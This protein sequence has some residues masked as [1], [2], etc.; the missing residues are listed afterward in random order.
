MK[1][2]ERYGLTFIQAQIEPN[3]KQ[4]AIAQYLAV[5]VRDDTHPR[6]VCQVPP[7]QGKSRVAATAALINSLN[8]SECTDKVHMVYPTE[9]LLQRDQSIFEKYWTFNKLHERVQYHVGLEFE[10]HADDLIIIDESD[11]LLFE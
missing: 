1:K 11:A 5:A 4:F 6:L 3:N 9:Y 8:I 10:K 7:G 2:D